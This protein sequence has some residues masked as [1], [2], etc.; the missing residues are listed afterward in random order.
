LTQ[1]ATNPT[2]TYG[3]GELALQSAALSLNIGFNQAGVIGAGPN[4]FG[5]LV[6][7]NGNDALSGM[8]ISQILDAANAALAGQGLPAG[9]D[10]NRLGLLVEA[11]NLSFVNNT[12]S[13]WATAHLS[14]PSIV[15]QCAAQVPDPDPAYALAADGCSS[16]VTVTSLSDAI[17]DYVNPSHYTIVRTWVATDSAGNTNSTSIR[18]LVNDTTAP[19]LAGQ[20]NR[21]VTAGTAWDFDIPA[22]VDNCGGATV[23]VLSTVT[24]NAVAVAGQS[25]VLVTRTWQATDAAGNTNTCQQGITVVTTTPQNPPTIVA[26]PQG[27]TIG[28]GTSTTLSVRVTG[29]GPFAYQWQLNGTNIAGANS[30]SLTLSESELADGGLY[31]VVV[32]NGSGAT[33]SQVA[34]VN[35]LPRLEIKANG[36]ILKLT[37]PAGFILQSASSPVGSYT[38]VA[39][40][41]SPYIYNTVTNA[42]KY[43]RLRSPDFKLTMAPQPGG[44]M[45]ITGPGVPGCNFTLQASADLQ[46]WVDVQTSPSPCSFLDAEA[47]LYPNRYY[48]AVLAK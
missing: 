31:T 41:V 18:I 43:F 4:N 3:G 23:S 44:Q 21:T 33:T 1:G 24:N 20:P 7:S 37:W 15:V 48:R 17:T 16:L 28:S 27:Q 8:T 10:F 5:S 11:L 35:V 22:A 40:A 47:A 30:R 9:Y 29:S 36:G 19:I 13:A 38:D 32:S 2:E 45:S 26:S 6:Y 25:T 34:V 42:Q 46:H 39:G 12:A 14:A